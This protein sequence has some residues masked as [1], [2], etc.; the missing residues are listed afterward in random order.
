LG[1]FA[2]DVAVSGDTLYA[3]GRDGSLGAFEL[4]TGQPR[5]TVRFAGKATLDPLNTQYSVAATDNA[6]YRRFPK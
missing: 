1:C 2:S 4:Q 5:G 3:I 6:A